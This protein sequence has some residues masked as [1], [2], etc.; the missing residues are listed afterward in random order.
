MELNIPHTRL[1]PRIT[2]FLL[3]HI[4]NINIYIKKSMPLYHFIIILLYTQVDAYCLFAFDF[5]SLF[6]FK[7]YS[8]LSNCKSIFESV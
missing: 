8:P 1:I 6:F 2:P 4:N 5:D 3:S 7:K